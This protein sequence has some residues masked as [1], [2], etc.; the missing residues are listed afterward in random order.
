[1]TSKSVMSSSQV[2]RNES[3]AE[4]PSAFSVKGVAHRV[5]TLV[6]HLAMAGQQQVHEQDLAAILKGGV[7][8]EVMKQAKARAAWVSSEEEESEA[9][10]KY[11]RAHL[12]NQRPVDTLRKATTGLS[13]V[14]VVKDVSK[15][16]R[17]T[18]ADFMQAGFCYRAKFPD[19]L[20]N[21]LHQ[22][23]YNFCGTEPLHEPCNL[24][25]CAL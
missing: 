23:V 6:A 8:F 19:A 4:V 17:A 22:G 24:S 18:L 13:R 12:R 16:T 15:S 2:S 14:P 3:I 5:T 1:M 21:L 25:E 9:R 11:G 7:N 10:R 20:Q